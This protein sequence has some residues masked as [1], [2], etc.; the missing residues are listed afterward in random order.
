MHHSKSSPFKISYLIFL[1][2]ISLYSLL[3]AGAPDTL[4]TRAYGGANEDGS[5]AVQ[6]TTD[7]GFIITGYTSSPDDRLDAYLIRINSDGDSLWTRTFH[8]LGDDVG[9]SVQ[10]TSDEGFIIAGRTGTIYSGKPDVYLVRTNKNGDTLW[11]QT[12]GDTSFDYGYSVQQTN[13]GGFIIAGE[14]VFDVINNENVYLVRTDSNGNKIWE[15]NFGGKNDDRGYSLSITRDEGF[16]ITGW[17][18]S[19]STNDLNVYLI[20]TNSSGD[21]LWTRTYGGTKWDNGH[22]VIQ[23]KDDGYIIAGET[24]SFGAGSHDIYL[25]RT[26]SHGDTLWTKTCGGD[27]ADVGFSIQQTSDGGFIVAGHTRSFGSGGSDVYLIRID[28][29]TTAI[30]QE[31]P[32]NFLSPNDFIVSYYNNNLISIRYTIQHSSSVNLSMYN[33]SGQLVKTLFNEYKNAGDYTINFKTE[34]TSSRLSGVSSGVYYFKR[35]FVKSCG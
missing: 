8:N 4:W 14:T 7:G 28:K 26:D 10:Q 11:T 32:S 2:V 29:D 15:R 16:I 9:L 35:G 3:F 5:H 12:Y 13:D 25:I 18:E 31:I 6:Q 23:T 22:S 17:T 19:F 27:S 1:S 20:R 30:H 34:N 21:T 33:I 24:E